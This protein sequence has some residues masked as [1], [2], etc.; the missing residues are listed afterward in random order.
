MLTRWILRKCEPVCVG[1]CAWRCLYVRVCACICKNYMYTF[2]LIAALSVRRCVRVYNVYVFVLNVFLYKIGSSGSST[3]R[4]TTLALRMKPDLQK[5]VARV[6]RVFGTFSPLSCPQFSLFLGLVR[7]ISLIPLTPIRSVILLFPFHT[8]PI[9]R[10]CI[11][12]SLFFF[13]QNSYAPFRSCSPPPFPPLNQSAPHSRLPFKRVSVSKSEY[14]IYPQFGEGK[15]HA[16]LLNPRFCHTLPPTFSWPCSLGGLIISGSSDRERILLHVDAKIGS[17]DD[18]RRPLNDNDDDDNND[19]DD[20]DDDGDDDDENDNACNGN[21]DA[22]DRGGN[23]SDD[24]AHDDGDDGEAA[25][26]VN[27]ARSRAESSTSPP[28]DPCSSAS[29][30]FSRSCCTWCRSASWYRR[31]SAPA[32]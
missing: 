18:G 13:R 5:Y 6:F 15:I 16:I 3:S 12:F 24:D 29:S 7:S 17:F 22:G 28:R 21:D 2:P 11:G 30:S 14:Q 19:D 8:L 1:V 20:D 27:A 23:N 32:G 4:R 31:G 9:T 26:A 25:A 10:P